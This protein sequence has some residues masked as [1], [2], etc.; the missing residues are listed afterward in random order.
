M[1][2]VWPGNVRELENVIER[3][4]ILSRDGTLFLDGTFNP[5]H[6]DSGRA[7]IE[8]EA[9]GSTTRTAEPCATS[10]ALTSST[11]ARTADGESR[12][13]TRHQSGSG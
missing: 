1:Q 6:P 2:Y 13:R 5:G 3:A 8:R 4:I 12:A 9:A 10:S 7:P 11:S